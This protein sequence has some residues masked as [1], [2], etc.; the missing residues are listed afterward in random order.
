MVAETGAGMED[1]AETQVT[2]K[3]RYAGQAFELPI[4]GSAAPDPE[5]LANRFEAAHRERYGHSDP[6]GEVVL[7]HIRLAMVS[8]APDPRPTAAESA[9]VARPAREVRFAGEWVE[10]PVIRG[11]PPAGME[12][13]GSAVFE[14][15]EATFVL[16]PGWSAEVDEAGTIRANS[17][18][19]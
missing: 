17:E 11:E 7:V 2:Y 9:V 5:E 6:D 8:P 14:L 13:D 10:T 1:E 18:E 4:P 12:T 15:P 19:A 16:P 3:L